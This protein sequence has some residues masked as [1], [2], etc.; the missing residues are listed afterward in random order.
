MR[1]PEMFSRRR[2]ERGR[3]Q[4]GEKRQRNH[5][6]IPMDG[7]RAEMKRNRMHDGN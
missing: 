5:H 4:P 3:P 2:A 1:S 6:A 7:E